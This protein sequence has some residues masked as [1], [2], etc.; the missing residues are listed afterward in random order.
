M[1][2]KL[3]KYEWRGLRFPIFI[4]MGIL[5]AATLLTCLIILT[6]DPKLDNVASGFSFLSLMLSI[7][8]YYFGVIGCTLGT[9]LVVAIRFYKTTYTDQ[10]YLTH[11]LPVESKT[12]LAAK[13]IVSV[14][15]HLMMLTCVVVTILIIIGVGVYHIGNVSEYWDAHYWHRIFT[16][17][18]SELSESFREEYGISLGGFVAFYLVFLI[19]SSISGI[20][21]VLGCISLGQLYAKHRILGAI[22]AY[23]VVIGVQQFISYLAMMPTYSRM[24]RAEA[25]SETMPMFEVISPTMIITLLWSVA[26]SVIMH[27]IN[28]HMMTKRL[29]LE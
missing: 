23:F 15:C 29:N 21:T 2:G 8:L 16:E 11:T 3:M 18:F 27:L 22:I 9:M 20:M 7:M 24:L 26:V 10:G 19:I 28:L 5:G 4:M 17:G 1:L 14:I 6:I 12:L 25:L 13:T